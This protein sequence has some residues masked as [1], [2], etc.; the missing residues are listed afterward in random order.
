MPGDLPEICVMA[1]RTLGIVPTKIPVVAGQHRFA[2]IHLNTAIYS[3]SVG[4]PGDSFAS[5]S[6]LTEC[7]SNLTASALV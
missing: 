4:L 5:S 7:R 1:D 6:G 2:G 3:E